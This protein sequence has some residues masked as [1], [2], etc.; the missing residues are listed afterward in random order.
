MVYIW[1]REHT[2][3]SVSAIY[4]ISSGDKYY[5]E[6]EVR[7]GGIGRA[8]VGVGSILNAGGGGQ[9]RPL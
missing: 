5:V 2:V 1:G 4:V 9:Q 6:K 3:N 8:G 7:K